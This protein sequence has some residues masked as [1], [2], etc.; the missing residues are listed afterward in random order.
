PV[1][2]QE[3]TERADNPVTAITA[4]DSYTDEYVVWLTAHPSWDGVAYDEIDSYEQDNPCDVYIYENPHDTV[5]QF[6][7]WV[8]D[9][10]MDALTGWNA[11]GVDHPYLVNYAR[12]NGI[13]AVYDASPLG[14]VYPM[15]GDGNFINSSFKGRLLLD[16]LSLYQKSQIHE[17]DSYRL[18]DVAEAE[19]VSV[20]KL[21]LE[22]EVG[23]TDGEP[24]IDYAWKHD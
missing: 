1:V 18:A 10:D 9:R 8:T 22:S 3:G 21:D 12:L 24:A 5:A 19:G 20:G 13:G 7:E 14:E 6:F 17:L 11:S 16:S 2:S 23:E 15:D 4:H